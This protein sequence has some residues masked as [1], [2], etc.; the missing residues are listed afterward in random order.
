LGPMA[1]ESRFLSIIVRS[2]EV[3]IGKLIVR[4]SDKIIAVSKAVK[5]QAVWLGA[6]PKDVTVVPNGVDLCEFKPIEARGSEGTKRVACVGRLIPNK[7]VQFLIKA[8]PSVLSSN[9][10]VEFVIVG[11]GPMRDHLV[12]MT[13]DLGV[14]HAF[15]FMGTVPSVSD[16]LRDCRIF[17]RPSLTEGMPLTVLEAM[18]CGLPVVASRVSG[19]PEVVLDGETG[20]LVEAGNVRQI[21]EAIAKLL[22][23][24]HG[25]TEMGRN[26]LRLVGERYSWDRAAD[27]VQRVYEGILKRTN[28]KD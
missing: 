7:G 9:P 15:R 21:A 26:A 23:D 16:V 25:A 3:T 13:E 10:D 17:V 20:I 12:Q 2:Y 5:A 28:Q 11:D 14:K 4:L 22:S 8:S 6:E 27:L 24:D 19:T 18:A 1:F